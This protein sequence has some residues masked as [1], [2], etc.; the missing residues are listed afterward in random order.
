MLFAGEVFPVKHLRTLAEQWPDPPLLQPLRPDRDQ[1]LH[2]LRSQRFRSPQERT[3]PY[4]D[5]Q[6]LLASALQGRRS[7]RAATA[8]A[9]E[10]G[11]LC[12]SGR[13]VMQ[14]YWALPE[15]RPRAPSSRMR[16]G[17]RWYRTGDI[18]VEAPD[19]NYTYLGRRDRMVKRRGYRVELGEIEAGLYQ[20]P[21]VKEAAVVALARRRSGRAIKAF[22][23]CREEQ[24]SV[25]DRDEALLRRK[26]AALHDPRH[27]LVARRAARRPRPTRSTTSGSRT[28]A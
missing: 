3:V 17:T 10:E 11:E 6:A 4:P 8:R 14:G 16:D 23:S 19:G 7:Q 26:P 15:H 21:L 20:H 24:A 2:L 5:R 25:A 28:C 13:G 27:V 12:I 22:L 18:V 1:R 9:G